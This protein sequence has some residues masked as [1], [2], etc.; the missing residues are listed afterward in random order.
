[1][2]RL[3]ERRDL[4]PAQYR[5]SCGH[6]PSAAPRVYPP[7]YKR[8][9]HRRHQHRDSQCSGQVGGTDVQSDLHRC[10]KNGKGVVQ[11][12]VRGDLGDGQMWPL[13]R[14][15][16]APTRAVIGHHR[17]VIGLLPQFRAWRAVHRTGSVR[18]AWPGRSADHRSAH[19]RLKSFPS[20]SAT[21]GST[22]PA[23]GL[24]CAQWWIGIHGGTGTRMFRTLHHHMMP[25]RV[26][27]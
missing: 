12:A 21:D 6:Q 9:G 7:A 2:Y 23:E 17:P 4:G 18:P 24:R 26:S 16:Y 25:R 15:S 14:R 10:Q 27:N 11:H 22:D 13:S 8:C 3:R 5:R 20:R 19:Y 1:M